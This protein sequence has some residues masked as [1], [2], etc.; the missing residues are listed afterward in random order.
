MSLVH[1]INE[2]PLNLRTLYEILLND[3][4]LQLS[5]IATT[6]IEKCRTFLDQ[7][8]NG[9]S[10]PVY[11]INTG[12]GALHN[13]KIRGEDLHKLQENLVMSHACG[14]GEEAPKIIVKLMILLKIQSLSYGYSGV[15][16]MIVVRLLDFYNNDILPI[17]YEQG[18]LLYTSPSPRDISGSRMPSSA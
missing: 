5:S 13:V 1:T 12:F 7:K 2:H 11:G 17:V 9:I 6:R 18:C 16:R 15:Q 3:K 8:I 14:T 4:K 10:S